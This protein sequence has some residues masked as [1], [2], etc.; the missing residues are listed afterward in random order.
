MTTLAEQIQST[1]EESKFSDFEFLTKE[2]IE[3]MVRNIEDS[4]KRRVQS[5]M[6]KFYDLMNRE[7]DPFKKIYYE[8][9]MYVSPLVAKNLAIKYFQKEFQQG[10]SNYSDTITASSHDMGISAD[11]SV[12]TKVDYGNTA[13]TKGIFSTMLSG[14]NDPKR[15]YEI[16]D[17]IAKLV[18]HKLFA[19]N[20]PALYVLLT[21]LYLG[22]Q[23]Q[24]SRARAS[25]SAP[26]DIQ[27]YLARPPKEYFD[28]LD[29][30]KE[31][32]DAG[33]E[34]DNIGFNMII[35]GHTIKPEEGSNAKEIRVK[36]L[37]H[38]KAIQDAND[39]IEKVTLELFGADD[40]EGVKKMLLGEA[41]DRT[42]A[43]LKLLD[44]AFEKG[45]TIPAALLIETVPMLVHLNLRAKTLL[46]RT[47]KKGD[48]LVICKDILKRIKKGDTELLQDLIMAPVYK[49]SNAQELFVQLK[50]KIQK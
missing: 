21:R 31:L 9:R 16:A 30:I 27:S 43:M 39:I 24:F 11:D 28:V 46:S 33:I 3:Y 38:T 6:E 15:T 17:T 47:F 7:S 14:N 13:V 45:K 48:M 1:M 49:S 36:G 50:Q 8:Y 10:I 44:Y 35:L 20:K 18:G 22:L 40:V 25:Y 2:T 12:M 32:E 4:K 19:E 41:K 34:F 23:R 37:S 5:Q 26:M 42:A 29:K